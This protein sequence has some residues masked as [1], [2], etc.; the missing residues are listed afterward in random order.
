[1]NFGI[2]KEE[3]TIVF[4]GEIS[5]SSA[6]SLLEILGVEQPDTLVMISPGGQMPASL[7]IGRYLANTDI[8]VVIRENT[9][10]MSACAYAAMASNN[11]E[12]HGN[13][14]FHAP[15]FPEIS[16]D[17]TLHELF[18]MSNIANLT[19]LEWFLRNGYT[20][21]FYRRILENTDVDT[22]INFTNYE[23]LREFRNADPL[24]TVTDAGELYTTETLD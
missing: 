5:G 12:I 23:N 13:L 20:L 9:S 15:Y 16:T 24:H 2:F 21:D 19:M 22:F 8:K 18:V 14:M 1:M 10:C 3:N 6:I 17:S 11:L 4:Y 7:V